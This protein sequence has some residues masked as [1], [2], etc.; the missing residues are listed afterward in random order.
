VTGE[1]RDAISTVIL[2][3]RYGELAVT[4]SSE[5]RNNLAFIL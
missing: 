4:A 3:P 1:V 2:D 5:E